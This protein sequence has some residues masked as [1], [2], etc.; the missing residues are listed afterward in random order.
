MT[1]LLLVVALQGAMLDAGTLIVHYDTAE[2]ARERFALHAG[3]AGTGT[4]GW[5]LATSIRYHRARPALVLAPILEIDRDSVVVALQYDVSDPHEP[6]RILGEAGRGR[7]TVRFL[8]RHAERAREFPADARTVVLDDSVYALYLLA[9]WRADA[10]PHS[11]SVV[12]PRA[13][14]REDLT[15]QAH[16]EA[17]TL[18]HRSAV[19]LQHVT[20]RGGPNQIVHIWLDAEGRLMKIEIPSRRVTVERVPEG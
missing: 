4:A 2:V 6:M 20:L 10:T 15:V 17:S 7:F 19:R 8:A 3:R 13:L 12:V 9:A 1:P 14:R 16:G 5:T 18:I 11:L